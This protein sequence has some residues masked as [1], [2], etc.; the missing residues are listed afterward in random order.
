M[1]AKNLPIPVGYQR[2]VLRLL[3]SS[4]RVHDKLSVVTGVPN[5]HDTRSRNRRQKTGIGFWRVSSVKNTDCSSFPPKLPF[6]LYLT[7]ILIYFNV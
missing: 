6:N 3:A 4:A 7:F 2:S 5:A 1:L